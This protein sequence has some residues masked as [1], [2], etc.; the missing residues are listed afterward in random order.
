M[1]P[2]PFCQHDNPPGNRFCGQCGAALAAEADGVSDA[3]QP[4]ILVLLAESRKI[5]AIKLYRERTGAGLKDAKDA[6]GAMEKA[7]PISLPADPSGVVDQVFL[8]LL[9]AGSTIN[10]IKH[11]RR[12]TGA[13]LS[14]AKHVVARLQEAHGFRDGQWSGCLGRHAAIVVVFLD[15]L[16]NLLS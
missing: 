15:L 11:Y 10:A 6:V 7:R 12:V 4:Q 1:S 8:D 3:L 2:C 5:E 16:F 9:R 14:D 13:S